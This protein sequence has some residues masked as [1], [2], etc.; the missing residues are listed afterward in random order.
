MKVSKRILGLVLLLVANI[1]IGFAKEAVEMSGARQ[2]FQ[3]YKINGSILVYDQNKNEYSGYNLERCNIGFCPAS[4]FKIPNTLIAL[5]TGVITMDSIFH[6]NGEKRPF[7]VWESDMDIEHA[8]KV[9]N[10]PI[11]Q[12]IARHIGLKRMQDYVR[13]LHFGAMDINKENIDKF[14]LEGDSKI[15]QYQQV[16]FLHRLYRSELPLKTSTMDHVKQIMILEQTDDYTLRGKTGWAEINGKDI[17]WFV[18]YFE[19]ADNVYFFATNIEP[20]GQTDMQ[21]FG[22]DRIDL[23]KEIL[24]LKM[25]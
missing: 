25:K 14:W 22:K 17:G 13:L 15:T 19:T 4:T 12:D 21:N 24:S 1:A 7:Q 8:F 16:Y 6:W 2:I 18:G 3:K 11:Y 10:V 9:S 23:T 5:E 20:S